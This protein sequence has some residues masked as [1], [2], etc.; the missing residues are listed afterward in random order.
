MNKSKVDTSI[1]GFK[2]IGIELTN[3]Q[4]KELCQLN[5][6]LLSIDTKNIPVYGIL[7]VLKTLNLLPENMLCENVNKTK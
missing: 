1:E 3:E 6:E 7:L 4:Y 5:L 2:K